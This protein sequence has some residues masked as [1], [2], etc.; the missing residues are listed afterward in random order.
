MTVVVL[1]DRVA[2]PVL[3]ESDRGEGAQT[4]DMGMVRR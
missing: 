4:S 1:D 3:D 2:I